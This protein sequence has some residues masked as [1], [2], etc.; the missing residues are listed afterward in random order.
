MYHVTRSTIAE[1]LSRRLAMTA[2]ALVISALSVPGWAAPSDGERFREIYQKEWEFR[3]AEFPLWASG[4]GIDEHA[5]ELGHVAEADQKRRYE[6]WRRI[7]TE[8][9]SISCE[10]L[11]RA[12]CINYRLFVKQIDDFLAAYETR[13]YLIPFNSDWGF[14]MEWGRLPADTDF[15]S[16]ADYRNYLSRLSQIGPV[17]DEYIEL[18]RTG[19][20]IGM[21]Q[22]RVILDG[23]DQPIRRQLVERPEQ[24]PFF[25]PFLNMP[26]T[27]DNGVRAELLEQAGEVIGQGVV[28][29][30]RRL[31][32][33]FHGEYVPGARRTLG[34]Y[35]LPGGEAFYAAEIRR[36]ATV[37][38]SP[39]EIHDIG[40][41]EVARIR[42]EMDAV[43]EE[44][45]FEGEFADF[46]TFLRTDP[47]FYAKSPRELL[48]TAS[49]YAKKIDGRLPMLFGHLPRQPYGV[50]PVPDELA[51]FYTAG[52][53][54]GAPLEAHRGGYYWVNTWKLESR[55]LYA[56]PA[57]TLHEGAP[58]HH[59]QGALAMEQSDQPPFRRNDYISAFGEGWGL[60]AEKLG[61]EMDI[62]ETPYEQFGRLTYE[63]WRACRLVID[64]GVHAM[65]WNREQA[66]E[67][68]V[69]RTA[70]SV[71]EVT[72]EVDRYISWPA[73]ALS[74]KLGEYT[75]WQL[76][77]EAEAQLGERFDVRAFHDFILGLGSVTL[78]ILQDEVRSWIEAQG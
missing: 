43:I 73:Q 74:Y 64:T 63:M 5:A 3:M 4:N 42:A 47:R 68:L 12:E 17:M 50:A 6:Y 20:E 41:S 57:L 76:R 10:R 35:E 28:P 29:A 49:Y 33:F 77:R 31:Y 22:P 48:A 30:Y 51:E 14:Y 25:A 39:R 46:I 26:E 24:S 69:S 53:Y 21:T 70:L 19:I 62:Y 71:H 13:A 45:G 58:G 59:I 40:L 52:R 72:T 37:D 8:L 78:E 55:P 11:E 75:L 65:G 38:L 23:R 54:V 66:Q 2:A 56:I 9:D 7:R 60:Y 32:D 16:L 27:L 36:Y 67:Y 44:T 61:V 1:K 15:T 34:A 18:M